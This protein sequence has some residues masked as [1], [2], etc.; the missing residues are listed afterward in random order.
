MV[1]WLKNQYDINVRS[2]LV[3]MGTFR[4]VFQRSKLEK[5]LIE[6]LK[7]PVI[8]VGSVRH[9][10]REPMDEKSIWRRLS[11]QASRKRRQIRKIEERSKPRIPQVLRTYDKCA[12]ID[13]N[14]TKSKEWL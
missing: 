11:F 13:F 6:E 3:Y 9:S 10:C 1:E 8:V 12:L 5:E 2:N 7:K 4:R 14:L